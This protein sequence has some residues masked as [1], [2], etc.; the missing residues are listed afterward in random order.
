MGGYAT[1]LIVAGATQRFG[2]DEQ[3]ADILGG[4]AKGDV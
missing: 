3:K 2:T 1:T 4:I